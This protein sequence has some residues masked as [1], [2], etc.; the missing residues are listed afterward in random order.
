[1]KKI[2][3]LTVYWL[4]IAAMFTWACW[5]WYM[6]DCEFIKNWM[7]GSSQVPARCINL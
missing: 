2:V 4:F 5:Y 7:W 6:A 3:I 1:M